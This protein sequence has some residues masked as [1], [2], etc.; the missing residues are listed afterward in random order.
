MHLCLFRPTLA[1]SIAFLRVR[2]SYYTVRHILRENNA[3]IRRIQYTRTRAVN[4]SLVRALPQ[5]SSIEEVKSLVCGQ[6]WDNV[7]NTQ[8]YQSICMAERDEHGQLLNISSVTNTTMG[9]VRESSMKG[10]SWCAFIWA[11][12][13]GD[14]NCEDPDVSW[15]ASLSLSPAEHTTTPVG[16]NQF[17]FNLKPNQ[18]D[19]AK[20]GFGSSLL[21]SAYTRQNDLAAQFVTARPLQ[22]DVSSPAA[23]L[24]IATW[25]EKCKEHDCCSAHSDIPL[26]L[27][28]IEVSPKERPDHPRLLTTKGLKGQY[29]TLSYCWGTHSNYLLKT[30]NINKLSKGLD[31]DAIP[32]TIFDAIS[33]AKSIYVDYLWI[34]ALCILQD[35]KE[36][37]VIEL[38]KMKDIYRNSL[39]TIVAANAEEV[40]SG[41]LQ[42]RS[43]VPTRDEDCRLWT[44]RMTG[45]DGTSKLPWTIP[46]R[47]QDDVFGTM[48]LRCVECETEY[49]EDKEI[50]NTRAWTL[51]EQL[52]SQRALIYASHTLQWRCRAGT[53]NL[54]DSLHQNRYESE[55]FQ[56]LNKSSS[57]PR[58][59]LL[60]WFRIVE[61]Y[62][63]RKVSLPSDKLPAIAGIANEFLDSLGPHYYAGI[64]GGN[65][66]VSQLGWYVESLSVKDPTLTIPGHHGTTTARPRR[67]KYIALHRGHGLLWMVLSVCKPGIQ[68]GMKKKMTLAR[69]AKL[70]TWKQH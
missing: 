66:L 62:G 15:E 32:Q 27:R 57:T 12:R 21:V 8:A 1:S 55:T 9:Y 63:T 65:K 16:T 14:E 41:F 25:M 70:Y 38:A 11:F 56:T 61:R 10:C 28:V 43:G 35:S 59:A 26:P 69:S 18:N 64:W 4:N 47:V 44:H 67:R 31:M 23:R 58:E 45:T 20:K 51:Q 54:G 6:C 68:N 2:S 48:S 53:W 3:W 24:Q 50:I 37:K 13:H 60:R 30:S 49:E 36:D 40:S 19:D 42:P 7:F 46:F 52:M 17:Y 22:T 33:V 29:A 39:I 5:F 34:D